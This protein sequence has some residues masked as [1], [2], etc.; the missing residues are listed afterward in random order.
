MSASAQLTLVIGG[1]G[2][3][4]RRVVDRLTALGHP[5][6]I[7]SRSGQPPF[8]WEDPATWKPALD[9]ADR[10]YIVHPD[11]FQ[12]DYA[13]QIGALARAAADCGAR[14]L[15]LLSGR[16]DSASQT[17]E[18][19][20]KLPGVEW[21]V[22][23]AGWFNQNFSEAFFLDA[24]RAGELALPAGDWTEGFIDADDIA[25]VAVAAL[26]EDRH[27]GKTYELSGPRLL[28]FTDIAAELSTATGRH[29]T[30]TPL[31]P[32]PSPAD[33]P[34]IMAEVFASDPAAPHRQLA[35]GVQ[36]ALGRE[37]KDFSQYARETAATGIWNA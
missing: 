4:G 27:H 3:T 26:T 30:Y 31:T 25:D 7:G 16:G 17:S 19:N 9:G 34:D 15:V 22:V 5:V 35:H 2:K 11:P 23:R 20:I 8:T 1:T 33:E 13:E 10:I 24:V 6:R 29:I 12:P 32:Q 28:S 21:T 18:E 14:R 37:P 36:Q